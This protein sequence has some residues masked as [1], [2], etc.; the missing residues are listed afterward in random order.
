MTFQ[1]YLIEIENLNIL[2]TDDK[3]SEAISEGNKAFWDSIEQFFPSLIQKDFDS[4]NINAI[5]DTF[6]TSQFNTVKNW[7]KYNQDKLA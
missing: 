3:I 6:R 2:P 4:K 1:N 7:L 5:M